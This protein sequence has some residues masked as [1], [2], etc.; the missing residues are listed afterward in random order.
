MENEIN[1][2]NTWVDISNNPLSPGKFLFRKELCYLIEDKD[3]CL[4]LWV[5]FDGTVKEN[6]EN[7]PNTVFMRLDKYQNYSCPL[8]L[9]TYK[10]IKDENKIVKKLL[11]YGFKSSISN[12]N[13]ILTILKPLKQVHLK[14]W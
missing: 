3:T 4:R 6:R 5:G 1:T 13:Q 7:P 9:H 11:V 10:Y 14:S 8:D 2:L 12:L